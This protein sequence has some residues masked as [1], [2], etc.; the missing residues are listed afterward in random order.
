MDGRKVF[1]FAVRVLAQ[2]TEK[3]LQM[4][5]LHWMMLK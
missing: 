4:P 1:K 5:I 2:A 3:V